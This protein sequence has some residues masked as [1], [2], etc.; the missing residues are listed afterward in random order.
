MDS[1]MA[2]LRRNHDN[3]RC[4]LRAGILGGKDRSL[5]DPHGHTNTEVLGLA[6]GY[7]RGIGA[8]DRSNHQTRLAR[9]I[10]ITAIAASTWAK[11]K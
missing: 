10:E 11:V 1:A 5:S 9:L 4:N 6:W 2:R 7:R 8:G 3:M